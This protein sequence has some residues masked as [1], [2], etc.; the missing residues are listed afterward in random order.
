M[1][2]TMKRM[3]LVLLSLCLFAFTAEAKQP[4]A[5]LTPAFPPCPMMGNMQMPCPMA[6]LMQT[7]IDVMKIEQKLLA[8]SKGIDKNALKSE[9][10]QKMA[11]LDKQMADMKSCMPVSKAPVPGGQTVPC[12]MQ[13]GMP[14]SMTVQPL[15]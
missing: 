12:P 10:E 1:E 15:K 11:A 9:L 2:R 3:F 8:E 7:M 4:A 14:C 6:G 5:P 13:N